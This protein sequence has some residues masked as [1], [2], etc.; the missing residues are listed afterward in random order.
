MENR[1]S[2]AQNKRGEA[3]KKQVSHE[4]ATQVAGIHKDRGGYKVETCAADQ[5]DP[6]HANASHQ[7]IP[8]R[9]QVDD[10]GDPARWGRGGRICMPH[11][12]CP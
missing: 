10:G 11:I 2:R 7:C 12:A 5:F 9:V 6:T 1:S 4:S 8:L 3:A